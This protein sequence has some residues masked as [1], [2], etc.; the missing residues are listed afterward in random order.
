MVSLNDS[1]L[2]AIRPALENPGLFGVRVETLHGATLLDFGIATP[3]GYTAGLIFSNTCM[4]GMGQAWIGSA[5]YGAMALPTIHVA[6]GAPSLALMA[7]QYAGWAISKGKYFAMGSGPARALKGDEEIFKHIPHKEISQTAVLC[8]ETSKTP[9][10]EVIEYIFA[11]TGVTPGGLYILMAP[12]SSVTG[13][14]QISARVVETTIHKMHTVGFELK[15]IIAGCGSA[16]IAPVSPDGMEAIGRTN[17]CVLYGGSAHIT[18]DCQPGFLEEKIGQIPACASKDYGRTFKELFAQ[19]GDFYKIDPL[20]F[21]PARVSVANVRD[22]SFHTAGKID[23]DM[24][25]RSFGARQ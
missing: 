9:P 21:S 8:L 1:A 2:E 4:A 5:D 17:D 24:L 3:G 13:S 20:L 7:S 16:P 25:A 23:A 10:K 19:Y 22:G 18:V 11:K 15:D 6:S 12:T 14:T